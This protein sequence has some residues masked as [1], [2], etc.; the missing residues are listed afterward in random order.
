MEIPFHKPYITDDEINAVTLCLRNGWLTMGPKTFEFEERVAKLVGAKYAVAVNSGTAA[1]H[2]ALCCAGLEVGD[3]VIIPAMTFAATSEVVRYFGA[4]PVLA[5]IEPDTHLIDAKKISAKITPKTKAI[6]PVHYAGQPC[7]MDEIMRI[8]GEN[9]LMVIEDAAHALPAWYN[10]RSIGS[11]G[12]ITCFSFYATKTITTGEGGMAVTGNAEWAEK[13]RT[14]RLH[15]ISKDA[16]KRYSKDGSWKYDVTM[17]GFKYNTT[18]IASA[19]GIAQLDKIDFMTAERRRVALRYTELFQDCPSL[20]PYTVKEGRE[21]AWHLYPL[22]VNTEKSIVSRDLLY[23]KLKEERIMTSVHFIPLYHFS[24]Y[25]NIC[26]EPADYP[27]CESV[28]E[29]TISLPLYPGM[30]DEEIEFVARTVIAICG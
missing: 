12:H 4:K 14:L 16:W 25:R 8:A 6:I 27:V 20:V 9:D 23:I 1:L 3:E 30:K 15:G 2:L 28:F 17:N 29:R 26:G 24:A 21:S 10:G 5:D 13:M 22:K 11:I 7:D 18:D 19:M